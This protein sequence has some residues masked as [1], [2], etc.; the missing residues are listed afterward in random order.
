MMQ[1]DIRN[2]INLINNDS[3]LSPEEKSRAI[4]Q[5]M[6]GRSKAIKRKAKCD[7]YEKTCSD[8][9]FSCCNERD[10]C[11]R[12]HQENSDCKVKP[13]NITEITCDACSLVQP[14]SP[15]CIKC[16]TQFSSNYCA[17]CKI[18][19][20]RTIFHCNSCGICRVG[21]INNHFHCDTCNGC[22]PLTTRDTHTC[23]KR[24]MNELHCPVC[25][26]SIHSSQKA[27]HVAKCGH[28]FHGICLHRSDDYR[29]PLC[30]K[31]MEDMEANGS[32][33]RLRKALAKQPMPEDYF[34]MRTGDIVSSNYGALLL[35][36]CNRG[37]GMCVGRLTAWTLV[38]RSHPRAIIHVSQ[39][40]KERTVPIVCYECEQEARVEF[41]FIAMACPRCNG[42]NTART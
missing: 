30:R 25:L 22:F 14:P 19:T 2:S 39:L 40:H 1:Q 12:C 41:H 5:I 8:F 35:E 3:S 13:P 32:W 27:A 16:D 15:K 36:E 18:W 21:D 38:D 23:L 29:C 42:F 26:E 6:T 10:E 33:R 28:V 37:D 24:P 4:Q 17:L 9:M 20:K 34:D 11:H 31:A 7:H